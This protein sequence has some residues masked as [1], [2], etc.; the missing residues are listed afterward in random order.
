MYRL[1]ALPYRHSDALLGVIQS[2]ASDIESEVTMK[3]SLTN[4]KC[5]YGWESLR[6]VWYSSSYFNSFVMGFIF[7]LPWCWYYFNNLDAGFSFLTLLLKCIENKQNYINYE[8]DTN[9]A[10]T[11]N[12]VNNTNYAYNYIINANDAK[13]TNAK[14]KYYLKNLQS[15]RQS[16]E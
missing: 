3:A 8:N 15:L 7:W 4:I 16:C 6:N 10:D 13:H 11:T 5:K 2:C 1:I 12:D 14:P 9:S